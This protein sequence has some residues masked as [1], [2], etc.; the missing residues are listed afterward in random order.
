MW[1]ESVVDYFEYCSGIYLNGLRTT[2]KSIRGDEKTASFHILSTSLFIIY[3]IVLRYILCD[4]DNIVIK[5]IS[6][7][8]CELNSTFVCAVSITS[9]TDILWNV[10]IIQHNNA[11][12]ISISIC[13][14]VL[15]VRQNILI[16][17]VIFLAKLCSPYIIIFRFPQRPDRLWGPTS[18]LSDGCWGLLPRG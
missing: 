18:L 1:K 10:I 13:H 16:S 5:R 4:T 2:T 11:I 3:C 9:T 12:R 8:T 14:C 6:K 17:Y 15:H 7:H